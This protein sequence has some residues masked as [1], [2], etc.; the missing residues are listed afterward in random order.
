MDLSGYKYHQ[1]RFE[2]WT[3]ILAQLEDNI[4]DNGY[5]PDIYQSILKQ[6]RYHKKQARLCCPELNKNYKPI[7]I[8]HQ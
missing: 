5:E 6:V 4:L 8:A 7:Q 2:Y 3:G 1:E